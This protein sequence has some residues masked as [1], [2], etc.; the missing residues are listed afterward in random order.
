MGEEEHGGTAEARR[1]RNNNAVA[2]GEIRNF[3][4]IR[5]QSVFNISVLKWLFSWKDDRKF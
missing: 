4:A 3:F 5:R 2:R 1:R